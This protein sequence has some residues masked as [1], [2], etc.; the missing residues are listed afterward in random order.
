MMERL[1]I[2]WDRTARPGPLNM[3][4]DQWLLEQEREP[5]LRAYEWEGN[6]G[7]L[8]YF[9][10]LREAQEA[11][12]GVSLVRRATG[13]GIVDHR[14]D[15]TYTLIIPRTQSIAL[16]PSNESYHAIHLALAQAMQDEGV[17][18]DLVSR[19]EEG[20]SGVCFERPVQWDLVD[21]RG[22]KVAGAGQ[23]R[24][25]E[26]LL[27]QGSVQGASEAVMERFAAKLS[28]SIETVRR[29]PS[30]EE[31]AAIEKRLASARWLERR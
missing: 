16:A 4:I 13:G 31:L 27:H 11:L 6:W 3:A 18:V 9:G 7:S 28:S 14:S 10:S 25:R 22:Q 2:W 26:G 8:G 19:E 17:V 24:T 29:E 1:Q 30:E 5:L 23:R 20:G 21:S 12:P 15:R